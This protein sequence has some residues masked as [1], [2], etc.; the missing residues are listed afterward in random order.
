LS[1]FTKLLSYLGIQATD[2]KQPRKGQSRQ[3]KGAK[4][5]D[6]TYDWVARDTSANAELANG[7]PKLRNRARSLERDNPYARNYIQRRAI[8]VIGTGIKLQMRIENNGVPDDFANNLIEK[9]F[10]R[11]S[12]QGNCTV[13]GRLSF[14]STQIQIQEALNR[15]GEVFIRKYN[16]TGKIKVFES[17]YVDTA[18]NATAANGNR[19]IMGI[20]LDDN[21]KPLAYY[22]TKF[23][24]G[25]IYRNSRRYKYYTRIPAKDIIHLFKQN[26]PGQ[27]RGEPPLAPVMFTLRMVDGYQDAEVTAARLGANKSI[28]VKTSNDQISYDEEDEEGNRIQETAPGEVW[29]GYNNQEVTML[30]PKHPN[31]AYGDFIKENIR[32]AGSGLLTAYESLGNNRSDVNFSSIRTGR[33]DEIDTHKISQRYLIDAFLEPLFEWWLD[34]KMLTTL[35]V[36]R[37]SRFDEYN[38]AAEWLPRGYDW[39][40]PKKDAEADI[41]LIENTMATKQATIRKRTGEDHDEIVSQRI[42]E[43]RA[44]I[45]L[46]KAKQELAQLQNEQ[47]GQNQ[48]Q[49]NGGDANAE[50]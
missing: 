43:V 5:N 50:N 35:S 45:E 4:S 48:S 39:V 20:E 9:Q 49:N 25:D 30:D 46:E 7:L 42:K 40:D 14:H 44:E 47:N 32:A 15:D 21:D 19:I 24:P 18:Y 2:V 26:R 23:H 37:F 38:D 29:Y 22:M 27:V 13:D 28:F 11:W 8:N 12:K 36:L 34:F 33:L 41:L 16:T 31:Q 6:L 10:K 3:Y 17:D 1:R